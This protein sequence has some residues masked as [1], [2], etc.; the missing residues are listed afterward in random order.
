MILLALAQLIPPLNYSGQGHQY[1]VQDNVSGQVMTLAQESH[2]ALSMAPLYS[3]GKDDWDV[4]E[5]DLFD[6]VMPSDLASHMA[7]GITNGTIAFLRSRQLN[8]A[9]HDFFG[10]V[11]PLE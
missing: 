7:S 2:M 1:E 4:E 9:A 5:H 10:Y 11:M 6:H 3:L 8:W